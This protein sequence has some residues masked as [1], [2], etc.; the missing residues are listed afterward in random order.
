MARKA[1]ARSSYARRV[2]AVVGPVEVGARE[3]ER[4]DQRAP[5]GHHHDAAD[6]V[7][8]RP[9]HATSGDD[10]ACE[11][12][13]PHRVELLFDG[14]GPEV[15]H[16]AGVDVAGEVVVGLADE[17]PVRD[18]EE[19]GLDRAQR[20]DHLGR[21]RDRGEGRGR[22]RQH[23][24]RRGQQP[25]EAPGIEPCEADAALAP[26]IAQ[27]QLGHQE[28]RE[29]EEDIDADEP[30]V[31]AC[32][33]GVERDHEIHG[34]GAQ[35]V[36]LGTVV[37]GRVSD[38]GPVRQLRASCHHGSARYDPQQ[39][40]PGS[41]GQ[42]RSAPGS[43][44]GREGAGHALDA[45]D[46]AGGRSC[47]RVLLSLARHAAGQADVTA[48]FG[49]GNCVPQ[50]RILPRALR[51]RPS[52]AGRARRSLAPWSAFVD[53]P[54]DATVRH[55]GSAGRRWRFAGSGRATDAPRSFHDP[56][57]RAARRRA[58]WRTASIGRG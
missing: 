19:R 44:R 41:A 23:D 26:D 53:G 29:H 4:R 15:H 57:G 22:D 45:V 5:R 32:E 14:E 20:V 49:S 18:I 1:P 6:H 37:G 10:Q 36:E 27:Q 24:E 42:P 40:R 31:E 33:A 50:V 3:V 16:R 56:G 48:S 9:S 13:G 2:R 30:A 46:E 38:A 52:M 12:H 8:L 54:I 34:D 55:V 28:A 51:Y 11:Q 35:P 39:R 17:E 25:P 43:G 7:P 47:R 21:R 58:P